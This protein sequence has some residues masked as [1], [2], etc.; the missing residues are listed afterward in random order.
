MVGAAGKRLMTGLEDE[1]GSKVNQD[2][3]CITS[4]EPR[5][6]KGIQ[7]AMGKRFRVKRVAVVRNLGV[8]FSWSHRALGVHKAKMVK[9]RDRLARA[10]RIRKGGAGVRDLCRDRKSVV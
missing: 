9:A 3:T 5:V 2:K 1:L 6:A 8:G 10:A 4:T 7:K